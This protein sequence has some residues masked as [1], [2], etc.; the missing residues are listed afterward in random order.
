MKLIETVVALAIVT[1]GTAVAVDSLIPTAN[2]AIVELNRLGAQERERQATIQ[3]LC[4]QAFGP[5]GDCGDPVQPWV[6]APPL[7]DE[8]PR[9][10]A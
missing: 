1:G 5:E 3:D 7:G 9:G 10:G 4:H 6:D 2:S 8:T